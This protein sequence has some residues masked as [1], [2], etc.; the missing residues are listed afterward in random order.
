MKTI[1]V[2][3]A[4]GFMGRN[5]C[6][7]LRR[8]PGCEP[9]EFDVR[10]T[11]EEL[12]ALASRA[13]LVFHLAGVNRPKE[14]REFA[15]GNARLTRRLCDSLLA[16]GRKTPLVLSS[17]AQVELDNPYGRSKKAAEDAVLDYHRRSG[18]PVHIYRF[19][20]VFGK[21]SRPNYNTVVAT[22]CYNVSRGLPVQVSNRATVIRFVHIDDV[23]RAFLRIASGAAISA[24][25]SGGDPCATHY[26]VQP[27][28]SITL[29]ELHDLI[30]SFRDGR[31]QLLVPDL[32]NPLTR[33]LHST[34]TSFLE[35]DGLSRQVDL[36]SDDRGWL[37]EL[38]KSPHAGQ[39]FVSRTKPGITRG[40]HYHDTKI[41]K[42]CVIQG[43]GVIRFRCVLDS[44][45]IEYPVSDRAIS[46]VD[47]PPGC[48]HSVENTGTGDMITLF[49]ANEVLDPQRP[50]V[51]FEPVRKG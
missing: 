22:F 47:I 17:S 7:A 28:F 31:E 35:M 4:D 43:Q 30:V 23:V 15:E 3:G 42:F 10:Q 6:V 24:A 27:V 38:V 39:I 46:I 25:G 36:K 37:F 45:V 8:Q 33:Y 11:L 1:L 14:E 13:D 19:P 5:L 21:W 20:N 32:S 44:R 29:G 16:A 26:E 18:A 49:W 2:T 12:P 48:T 51:Y 50:D 40:N 9:I 41:E 34:Y